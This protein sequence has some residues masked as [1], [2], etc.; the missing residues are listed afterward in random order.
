MSCNNRSLP[1]DAEPAAPKR[2]SLQPRHP[3]R[4][5]DFSRRREHGLPTLPQ[6]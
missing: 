1:S 6:L 4:S 2:Q 3:G 5:D